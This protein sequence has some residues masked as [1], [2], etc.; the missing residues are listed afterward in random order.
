MS[1]DEMFVAAAEKQ[2]LRL[3]AAV[4]SF[5]SPHSLLKRSSPPEH[6]CDSEPFARVKVVPRVFN[7]GRAAGAKDWMLTVELQDFE[8]GVERLFSKDNEALGFFPSAAS[9]RIEL[10][11]SSGNPPALLLGQQVP[12]TETPAT[13]NANAT[14]GVPLETPEGVYPGPLPP[15][16]CQHTQSYQQGTTVTTGLQGTAPCPSGSVGVSF[17]SQAAT[18]Q[19]LTWQDHEFYRTVFAPGGGGGGGASVAWSWRLGM[20][21]QQS[22]HARFPYNA[23]DPAVWSRAGGSKHRSNPLPA[24]QV[25]PREDLEDAYRCSVRPQGAGRSQ[26]QQ[27]PAAAPPASAEAQATASWRLSRKEVD[28]LLST[29]EPGASRFELVVVCRLSLTCIVTEKGGCCGAETTRSSIGESID[30]SGR[31]GIVGW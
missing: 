10:V 24:C 22:D 28:A 9:I 31:V 14:G 20:W 17:T 11:E 29:A 25:T 18:S 30:I 6:C 3:P 12:P 26:Q 27:Q 7:L 2:G 21:E 8:I 15:Q 4:L 23:A 5:S 13:A 16:R 1:V 19:A